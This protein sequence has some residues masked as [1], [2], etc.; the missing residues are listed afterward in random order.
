MGYPR[1]ARR[2]YVS[3][4]TR[5][6]AK[7]TKPIGRK[8]YNISFATP[9]FQALTTASAQSSKLRFSWVLHLVFCPTQRRIHGALEVQRIG[10]SQKKKISVEAN[11]YSL[12]GRAPTAIASPYM[13]ARYTLPSKASTQA[14]FPCEP[15]PGTRRHYLHSRYRLAKNAYPIISI[16]LS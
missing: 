12:Y 8:P 4:S 9:S 13:L 1:T 14:S 7:I 6:E 5:I 16:H 10:L 3:P 15:L 11:G 2:E